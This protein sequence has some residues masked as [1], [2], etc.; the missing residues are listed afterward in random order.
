MHA[1]LHG[2]AF[3]DSCRQAVLYSPAGAHTAV[4]H[5][6][7]VCGRVY[8]HHWTVL[9]G[10][11]ACL[12]L[13]LFPGL[14][15]GSGQNNEGR[16]KQEMERAI[17]NYCSSEKNPV[18]FLART[19]SPLVQTDQLGDHSLLA[20]SIAESAAT[21]ESVMMPAGDRR[22]HPGSGITKLI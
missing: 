1:C 22:F 21:I 9:L 11:V 20:L 17:S 12:L 18:S 6:A 3:P 19:G 8:L 5:L 16:L 10:T 7:A 4:A 15:T 13:F 14:S 2:D